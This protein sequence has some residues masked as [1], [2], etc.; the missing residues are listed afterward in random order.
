VYEVDGNDVRERAVGAPVTLHGD[1]IYFINAGSVDASRKHAHKLAEFAL[2]DSAACVVEF[3]QV[4][5]DD[6]LTET[7]AT[8][9]GYRINRWADRLYDVRRRITGPR[10]RA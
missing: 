10:Q 8:A 1:R 7:K 2:F 4:P 9:G 5:Y 6:T 3:F